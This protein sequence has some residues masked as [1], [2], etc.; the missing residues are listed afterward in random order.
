MVTPLGAVFQ[1]WNCGDLEH[2]SNGA[3]GEITFKLILVVGGNQGCAQVQLEIGI[4]LLASVFI[5]LARAEAFDNNSPAT[6]AA[7]SRCVVVRHP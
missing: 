4:L 3:K 7:E 2:G 1:Y 6:N 5:T